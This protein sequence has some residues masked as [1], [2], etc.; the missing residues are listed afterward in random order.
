MHLQ[1]PVIIDVAQFAEF[2]HEVLLTLRS[3]RSDHLRQRFLT[4]LS[5]DGLW[6]RF[7]AEIRK[8]QQQPRKAPFAGIEQLIYQVLF[9]PSVASQ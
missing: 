3:R 4:D 6:S 5:H 2:V 8:E 1:V 7:L 9:D